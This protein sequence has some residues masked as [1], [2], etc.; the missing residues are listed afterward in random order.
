M[1]TSDKAWRAALRAEHDLIPPR[2]STGFGFGPLHQYHLASPSPEVLESASASITAHRGLTA[3][4]EGG[5]AT[6]LHIGGSMSGSTKV[7]ACTP[8]LSANA[9]VSNAAPVEST[10]M[11]SCGSDFRRS[12]SSVPIPRHDSHDGSI[13]ATRSTPSSS[14]SNEASS[15]SSVLTSIF[16]SDRNNST[17]PVRGPCV[18]ERLHSFNSFCSPKVFSARTTITT[19][20]ADSANRDTDPLRSLTVALSSLLPLSVRHSSSALTPLPPLPRGP[21][22]DKP[23]QGQ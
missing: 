8:Y 13:M 15:P 6:L 5:R 11:Q 12:P 1:E 22:V 4:T 14:G 9:R 21:S 2:D 3:M 23:S 10:R 17:D 20:P 16:S 18:R 19:K 7:T